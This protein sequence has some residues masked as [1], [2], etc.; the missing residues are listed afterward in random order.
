MV[1]ESN[2][3]SIYDYNAYVR[4]D[5]FEQADKPDFRVNSTGPAYNV[6]LQLYVSLY[7]LE[8]LSTKSSIGEYAERMRF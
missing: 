2:Y 3:F 4:T 1:F 6:I 8:V 5:M 7:D